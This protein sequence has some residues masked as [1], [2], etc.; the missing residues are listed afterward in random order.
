[1]FDL[2]FEKVNW[3]YEKCFEKYGKFIS[4]YY[5]F[6]IVLSVVLNVI[7]SCGIL[8]MKMI[9]DTD[10]LFMPIDSEAR[11]DE[12]LVKNLFNSSSLLSKDFYLHQLHDLGTWAEVNFKVK[13]CDPNRFTRDQENVLKKKYIEEVKRVNDFL[14]ANTVVKGK[15]ITFET[16]CARRN[17]ECLIDGVDLLSETFYEMWLSNAVKSKTRRLKE[18][19]NMVIDSESQPIKP[20]QNEFRFYFNILSKNPSL[21]DLT[22]NLGKDFYV[23][24][25]E[26]SRNG[27]EL[28]FSRMFKLRYNLKSDFINVR[29]DVKEWELEF[30]KSIEKLLK[31]HSS[32]QISGCNQNEE[33]KENEILKLLVITYSTSQSLDL[34]MAANIT[35]DTKLISGTFM[36]IMIFAILFMSFN[37]NW[38]TSPGFILPFAGIMSAMFG[39]TSAFGFLSFVGY[40]ACNLIFVIPFLVIGIGIDDMFI[41]YS[42]FTYSAAAKQRAQLKV[43]SDNETEDVEDIELKRLISATLAKSGVSITITSLTDFVAFL[44]GLTTG[45]RSVQIFCIYAGFSIAFCYFYQLTLF[46]GF[47]C[48]HVRRIQK[49][50]TLYCSVLNSQS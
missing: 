40:P 43:K 42:S 10:A 26:E 47:L 13:L 38:V 16:V 1:M 31:Y 36:L 48:L 22:Y 28:A 41:I 3:F 44:V 24:S 30:L 37:T 7:L 21:T 15:N 49:K 32:S 8:K 18:E 46:C 4:K 25:E 39:I 33:R 14:L 17:G 29:E 19:I 34:E 6:T 20:K 9:T 2:L 45:F 50:K 5:I 35:L 23:N 12:V 11:R 27:T